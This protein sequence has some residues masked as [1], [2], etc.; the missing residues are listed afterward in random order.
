MIRA[1][2]R[3]RGPFR[4][5]IA[6]HQAHRGALRLGTARPPRNAGSAP[7]RCWQCPELSHG[8]WLQ[9]P[10]RRAPAGRPAARCRGRRADRRAHRPDKV[11][12][13]AGCRRRTP[14]RRRGYRRDIPRRQACRDLPNA[15]P[16]APP[17]I[18]DRPRTSGEGSASPLPATPATQLD[19]PDR[20]TSSGVAAPSSQAQ[21]ATAPTPAHRRAAP[22]PAQPGG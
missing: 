17:A 2:R 14:A 13:S 8:R 7:D 16:P 6:V 21:A 22:G 11:A 18:H 15:D 12:R 4:Q 19:A 10:R 20:W 3:E 1:D 9:P 5:T